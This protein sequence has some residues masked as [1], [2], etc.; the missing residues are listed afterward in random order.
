MTQ[1][2]RPMLSTTRVL[3]LIFAKIVVKN[4]SQRKFLEELFSILPAIRGR[5]N[6][7]NLSRYS[8]YNEVSFRRN[9]SKFFDWVSFN[10]RIIE[11]SLSS[12]RSVLIAV[13][14]ASF[15]SKSGKKTFGL[16]R[17]WSGCANRAQKGLE[18]TALA[19][20]EVSTAMTWTLDVC[21]T[22]GGL[23]FK[24]GKT[25]DYTRID[26]YI[27]QLL[28]CR[29]Y[30]K[31]VLYIVA[32]GY[33]AKQKMFCAVLSMNK[34]LITKL[35][36]DANMKYLLDRSKYPNAHGNKKY[37]G[38]VDW[39]YLDLNR[40]IDLGLHPKFDHLHIY[41][42][43]LYSVQFKMNLKVVILINTRNG[44]YVLLASTNLFQSAL[45]VIQFYALR[46]QIEFLFRDAKQFTGLNHCQARAEEKLDFHFNM[47]LAAINLYQIQ[48]KL[49]EANSTSI[50]SFIRK[51][52]N[53][54]LVSLLFDQLNSKAE[55]NQF[56]D[57]NQPDVQKIITWGEVTYK[58]AA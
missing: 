49:N 32:D 34:H 58:K 39:K 26:Y 55:L 13:V 2:L 16:G 52:Y 53:T 12:P 24:E 28:D 4:K 36:A 47:S 45:E 14:D 54:K 43:E 25:N 56:L 17:F 18:I 37:D 42:Q 20:I 11:L 48:M 23:S 33:Y 31:A 50:N 15:I 5:F 1:N 51:A 8:K 40:W 35:R 9:F 57:I 30:L 21:Q 22:P 27:E 19:L 46:F 44:K 7:C 38:K 29:T 41:T 10:Y 6:F 3:G